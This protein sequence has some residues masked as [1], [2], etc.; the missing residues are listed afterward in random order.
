MVLCGFAQ[1]FLLPHNKVS[2]Y[3]LLL[4]VERLLYALGAGWQGRVSW[5]LQ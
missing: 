4:C 5:E 3:T 1:H 2:R